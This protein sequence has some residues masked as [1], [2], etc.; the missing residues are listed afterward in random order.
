ML[1]YYK[2]FYMAW[3]RNNP[4]FWLLFFS[5]YYTKVSEFSVVIKKGGRGNCRARLTYEPIKR[6]LDDIN[7][8]NRKLGYDYVI[9]HIRSLLLSNK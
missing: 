4:C 9:S 3:M 8:P 6:Y 5:G 2:F 7:Y 1:K